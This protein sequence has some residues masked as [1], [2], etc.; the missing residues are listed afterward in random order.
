METLE[1]EDVDEKTLDKKKPP[2]QQW[3]V[4]LYS[5]EWQ[6]DITA[7]TLVKVIPALDRL[8]AYELV[9][10]SREMGK[11]ALIICRKKQAEGYC[12][13]LQRRGLPATIELHDVER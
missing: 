4:M 13:G 2:P 5:T 7:R 9:L 11:V 12:L 3:R 1:R 6:P 10:K 8:A